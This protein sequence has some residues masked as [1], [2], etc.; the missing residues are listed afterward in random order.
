MI[1][2]TFCIFMRQNFSWWSFLYI[3]HIFYILYFSWGSDFH[4]H[5]EYSWDRI[6]HVMILPV[7]F[8]YLLHFVLSRRQWSLEH[9]VYSSDRISHVMILPVHFSYLLHFV[10]SRR[11]WSLEHVVYSWDRISHVMILPVHFSYLLHF[12][13]SRRQWSLEHSVYSWDRISHDDSFCTF[14]ISSTFCTFHEAVIFM[15]ILNIHETNF[16]H[17]I[18]MYNSWWTPFNETICYILYFL[19]DSDLMNMLY[20]H[21]TEVLMMNLSIHFSYLLHFVLSR[22]QWSLE[23]FVFSWDRISH[24]DP[25]CTFFISSTFCTFHEAVIFMNILNIHETEFLMWWSFL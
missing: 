4:E 9:V 7:N 18:F 16:F 25:S 22:R 17:V 20:I 2:G 10:L 3:F 19:G 12:V 21:E 1:S 11:Q 8:S 23:H 14:F 5:F 15:N 24:D 13:L 6:S